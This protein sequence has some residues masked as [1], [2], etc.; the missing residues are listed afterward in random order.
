M[1]DTT[2]GISACDS[3][4]R[5]AVLYPAADSH[6]AWGCLQE[7]YTTP[8][9]PGC[10]AST[11]HTLGETATT[12]EIPQAAAGRTEATLKLGCTTNCVGTPICPTAPAPDEEPSPGEQAMSPTPTP[13]SFMGCANL[14]R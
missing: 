13:H 8:R 5:A 3:S 12:C 11:G 1:Q 6:D 4:V 14:H 2:T 10:G 9:C 7:L